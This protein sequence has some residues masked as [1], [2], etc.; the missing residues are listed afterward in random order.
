MSLFNSATSAFGKWSGE[1]RKTGIQT[2]SAGKREAIY[3]CSLQGAALE[4][5]CTVASLK[6]SILGCA[7]TPR[8]KG[9]GYLN[10]RHRQTL[11]YR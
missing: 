3:P 2:Q 11:T 10:C 7:N 4:I 1:R 8:M 6:P 9:H 5:C